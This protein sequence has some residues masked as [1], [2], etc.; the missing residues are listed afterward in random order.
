MASSQFNLIYIFGL[1]CW[2][3]MKKNWKFVWLIRETH[4]KRDDIQHASHLSLA[5]VADALTNRIILEEWLI[6]GSCRAFRRTIHTV[7]SEP[8]HRLMHLNLFI[9]ANLRVYSSLPRSIALQ[10][11][12]RRSH[13]EQKRLIDLFPSRTGGHL[14]EMNDDIRFQ[15]SLNCRRSRRPSPHRWICEL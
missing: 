12:I 15:F 13:F 3:K 6:L 10:I 11:T 9:P 2:L 4:D 7:I 14:H 5:G 1:N 8:A